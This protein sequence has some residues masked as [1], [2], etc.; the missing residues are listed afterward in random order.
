MKNIISL[1]TVTFLLLV[2][3]ISISQS[4][5]NVS[6][7]DTKIYHE[8]IESFPH[9]DTASIAK[10]TIFLNLDV[11][12]FNRIRDNKI[13]DLELEIPFFNES[14]LNLHLRA[15]SSYENNLQIKRHTPFGEITENYTPSIQTYRV[16]N[17]DNIKGVFVFSNTG[18]KAVFTVNN[19]TYHISS[20]KNNSIYFIKR[21][22]ML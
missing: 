6:S 17:N 11:T 22:N 12:V 15:F 3:Q 1:F 20:F 10:N 7:I 14:S 13:S 16:D 18:L 5:F 8:M 9:V 2:S 4:L 19:H 21:K